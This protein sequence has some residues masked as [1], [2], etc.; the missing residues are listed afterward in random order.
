VQT[1]NVARKRF[2][3]VLTIRSQEGERII[4][5]H[6]FAEAHVKE[7]HA[8][9]IAAGTNAHECNAITMTRIHVRLDFEHEAGELF[10]S[11]FNRT[12]R[13]SARQGARRVSNE[14]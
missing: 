8:F 13:G 7:P 14:R 12:A 3:S 10:F 6:L 2:I 9:R 5:A 4:D 1:E 11:R